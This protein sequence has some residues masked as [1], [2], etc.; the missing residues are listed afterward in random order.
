M[1][2]RGEHYKKSEIQKDL[3]TDAIWSGFTLFIGCYIGTLTILSGSYHYDWGLFFAGL[4]RTDIFAYFQ[5]FLVQIS[6]V[7]YDTIY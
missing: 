2:S 6:S 7:V 5:S 3:T 4:R 1:T